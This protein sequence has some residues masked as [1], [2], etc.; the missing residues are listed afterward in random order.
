M[1][2]LFFYIA[3]FLVSNTKINAQILEEKQQIDYRLVGVWKGEEKD[4]QLEGMTKSW[5]MTRKND[6]TFILNFKFT[7]NGKKKTSIEKGKWW[8]EN[9]KFFEFHET[10]GMT[11]IYTYVIISNDKIKF[12]AENL[13][14]DQ[15]NENYEFIDERVN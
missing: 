11:D 13:S 9:G 10:S 6:G 8:I 5:V 14:I 3:V 15:T 1:K 7:V 4:N 12:K 2:N